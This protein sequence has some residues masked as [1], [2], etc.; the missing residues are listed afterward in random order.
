MKVSK[1]LIIVIEPIGMN[2]PHGH[3][4]CPEGCRVKLRLHKI[5]DGDPMMNGTC[6]KIDPVIDPCTLR[7]MI[8][9]KEKKV[10]YAGRKAD[11]EEG[12]ADQSGRA[13][14]P[15]ETEGKESLHDVIGV[16]FF[17]GG[18]I[19]YKVVQ[20]KGNPKGKSKRI[21]HRISERIDHITNGK[22]SDGGIVSGIKVEK[23]MGNSTIGENSIEETESSK[24]RK[25]YNDRG[26]HALCRVQ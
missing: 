15:S 13:R 19:E 17:K 11:K 14:V 24:E 26:P 21:V 3:D 20:V 23:E 12:V 8:T 25:C 16:F 9:V 1:A 18:F 4:T 7:F 6:G 2:H 22:K 10:V 5:H